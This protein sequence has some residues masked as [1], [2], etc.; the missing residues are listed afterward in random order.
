MTF[1]DTIYDSSELGLI[2][3][4]ELIY[5]LGLIY[6]LELIWVRTYKSPKN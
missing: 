4:L 6:E 5:E 2:Y 3:E 1:I